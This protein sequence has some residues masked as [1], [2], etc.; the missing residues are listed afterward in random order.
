MAMTQDP[1]QGHTP[2]MF[3]EEKMKDCNTIAL[4]KLG[5]TNVVISDGGIPR[6]DMRNVTADQP[7]TI[8][9]DEL[10][11]LASIEVRWN[12]VRNR[13]NNLLKETDW[14]GAV[15]V[16]QSI[17][18]VM[19]PYRQQLRDVTDTFGAPDDVIFPDKPEL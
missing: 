11:A 19:F 4:N 6:R 2:L 17:K 10:Y 15:D 14:A 3:T 12:E 13:R 9:Y 7:I 5:Y 16:P 1:D 18:D 8:T